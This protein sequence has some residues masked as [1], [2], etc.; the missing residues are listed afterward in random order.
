MRSGGFVAR[1][2]RKEGLDLEFPWEYCMEHGERRVMERGETLKET[3]EPTQ[4]VVFVERDCFK[5]MVHNDEEC[6]DY[7]TGFAFED[8]F[9]A[10][11]PYYLDGDV[12][13]VSIEADMLCEVSI[14]STQRL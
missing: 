14:I 1:L 12:S 2:C 9:V 8:D 7:F 13:E 4:W 3:G 10:D 6:K 5:Y 11:F